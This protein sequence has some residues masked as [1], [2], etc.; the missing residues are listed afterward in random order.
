MDIKL[1][2]RICF[3]K[4]NSLIFILLT[5]STFRFQKSYINFFNYNDINLLKRLGEISFILLIL[6]SLV[7]LFKLNRKNI[8]NLF[9]ISI[10]W[11]LFS[12]FFNF[13]LINFQ[14]IKKSLQVFYCFYIFLAFSNIKDEINFSLIQNLI[15]ILLSVF[16]FF[17]FLYNGII[18]KLYLNEI[19]SLSIILISLNFFLFLKPKKK[20]LVFTSFIIFYLVTY[21]IFKIIV[22]TPYDYLDIEL[23]NRKNSF[24]WVILFFFALILFKNCKQDEKIHQNLFISLIILFSLIFC[25]LYIFCSKIILIL[26]QIFLKKFQSKKIF[27][28]APLIFFLLPYLIIITFFQENFI[29]ILNYMTNKVFN[30]EN[31]GVIKV[32]DQNFNFLFEVSQINFQDS[33]IFTDIYLGLIHRAAIAK[34]YMSNL[35]DGLIVNNNHIITTEYFSFNYIDPAKTGFHNSEIVKN[36]QNL[37][38]E[39][40]NLKLRLNECA[41]YLNQ[42]ENQQFSPIYLDELI[43]TQKF[44][45]SHN[46]YIDLL[47]SFKYLTIILMFVI[48]ITLFKIIINN[49]LNNMFVSLVFITTLILNFDNYLFYNFFNVSFVIWMAL[50]LSINPHIKSQFKC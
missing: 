36:Y 35:F 29:Q 26:L 1:L 49:K 43:F 44:N 33:K 19:L 16:T 8:I 31:L 27:L 15:I 5:L 24:S 4:I 42:L 37:L 3:R 45:S 21:A 6:F 32:S 23:F 39:C 20:T 2:N 46:Q 10:I 41:L 9:V 47:N 18:N 17:S 11:I 28:F 48:G 13:Q 12:L 50:G 38:P 14:Y 34:I 25:S 40:I 22:D 7:Y 30:L